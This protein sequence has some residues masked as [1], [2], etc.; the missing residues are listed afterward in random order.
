MTGNRK[1]TSQVVGDAKPIESIN[2]V[3]KVHDAVLHQVSEVSAK[4]R[5]QSL[6]RRYLDSQLQHG[7]DCH[8]HHGQL[9]SIMQV[10]SEQDAAIRALK[11]GPRQFHARP[12]PRHVHLLGAFPRLT[13]S[14]GV[15]DSNTVEDAKVN[16]SE[17]TQYSKNCDSDKVCDSEQN[18]DE[19]RP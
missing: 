7:H 16:E 8:W 19:Q 3:E 14:K 17:R 15:Q 9:K 5:I 4:S 10:K 12:V 6:F 1:G 18:A 11:H 13:F 2:C